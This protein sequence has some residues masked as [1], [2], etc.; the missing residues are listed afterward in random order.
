MQL[1]VSLEQHLAHSAFLHRRLCPRQ[2]L[3]VRLARFACVYL[4]I[5]PALQPKRLFVYIENGHCFADGVIAVTR[6][7]LTNSAM[8]HIPYGKMAATFVDRANGQAVR[9]YEH[10]ACREA[11]VA[12]VPRAL[13]AW[14]AHLQAYQTMP[15][16]ELLS[17]QPVELETAL[18]ALKAKHSVIC[19]RCGDRVHEHSEVEL[20]GEPVCRACA[21]G[22]YYRV[23]VPALPGAMD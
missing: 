8:Q 15:D 11:A 17:W 10:P 3:G 16:E 6:A 14:A 9:V 21:Y 23:V 12:R 20:D 22:A 18:P 1:S 2:V 4:G 13:S 5:D 7:S 19:S